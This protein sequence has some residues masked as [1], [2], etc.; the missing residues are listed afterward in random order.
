[1]YAF[2]TV[3]LDLKHKIGTSMDYHYS[4]GEEGQTIKTFSCQ[5]P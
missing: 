3:T 2:V 5:F 1:M 4:V